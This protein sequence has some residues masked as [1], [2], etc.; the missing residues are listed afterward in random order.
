MIRFLE[1]I[2]ESAI[3]VSDVA[4][5]GVSEG[6]GLELRDWRTN[7]Q[8]GTGF[9]PY[10]VAEGTAWF[11][12]AISFCGVLGF[13]RFYLGRPLTAVLWLFTL[14]LF[15]VG[16]IVDA[17]NMHKMVENHNRELWQRAWAIEQIRQQKAWH[18][19]HAAKAAQA[20]QAE[21][22][23]AQTVQQ[24]SRQP[25]VIASSDGPGPRLVM[26][27]R[28]DSPITSF[29]A[30]YPGVCAVC[31]EP[32]DEGDYIYAVRGRGACHEDCGDEEGWSD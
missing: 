9:R 2:S 13:H 11:L 30:R 6:D 17:V 10:Q 18:D 1:P 4:L 31:G 25:Q 24:H 16:A 20:W 7:M 12:W 29:P 27:V 19:Y 14:G 5:Y 22:Q 8:H 3:Q 26:T 23:R 15:G 32:I 28:H 21:M